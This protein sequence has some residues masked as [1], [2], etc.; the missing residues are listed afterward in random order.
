MSVTIFDNTHWYI[1]NHQTIECIHFARRT[2]DSLE[3]KPLFNIVE[4]C[5]CD[6]DCD[7]VWP[8]L[9]E[10]SV[11]TIRW[12]VQF[13][14]LTD[15]CSLHNNG[16]ET[17][18]QPV[19]R[20]WRGNWTAEGLMII[21][22]FMTSGR[23]GTKMK[24]PGHSQQARGMHCPTRLVREQEWTRKNGRTAPPA[25]KSALVRNAPLHVVLQISNKPAFKTNRELGQTINH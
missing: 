6:D 2:L 13:F 21:F 17:Q 4:Y 1:R 10:L 24:R 14:R 18:E 7:H 25:R 12:S 20:S 5:R 8:W 15:I 11:V 22:W 23:L 3:N 16:N 9:F 19:T